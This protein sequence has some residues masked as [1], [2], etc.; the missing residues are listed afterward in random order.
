MRTDTLRWQVQGLGSG[1]QDLW[2]SIEPLGECHFTED[3]TKVI[4]NRDWTFLRL[5]GNSET[6]DFRARLYN[7]CNRIHNRKIGYVLKKPFYILTSSF[8]H[9]L[10]LQKTVVLIQNFLVRIRILGPQNTYIW[11][12]AFLK[13]AP[14]LYKYKRRCIKSYTA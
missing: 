11:I 12:Q 3:F 14:N 7:V 10:F 13:K 5:W 2:H 1:N 4:Q 8:P 6:S 9:A